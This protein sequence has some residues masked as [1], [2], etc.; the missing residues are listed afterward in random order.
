MLASKGPSAAAKVLRTTTVVAPRT[1]SSPPL[2]WTSDVSLGVSTPGYPLDAYPLDALPIK[3]QFPCSA[4][5]ILFGPNPN[6][7]FDTSYG[8]AVWRGH[9][10]PSES[11]CGRALNA[12]QDYHVTLQQSSREPTRTGEVNVGGWLCA[13]S[14]ENNL[15]RLR[16][17][18]A[19]AGGRYVNFRV[20]A[21]GL[22]K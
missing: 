16:Y 4:C 9:D 7:V 3:R 18:G 13:F 11:D 2:L 20:T 8:V 14:N 22:D 5:I 21:W 15:L 1:S 6:F 10:E 12:S 17:E 19:S